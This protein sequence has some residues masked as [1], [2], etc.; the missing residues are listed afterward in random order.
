MKI[1]S[2]LALSLVLAFSTPAPEVA[3]PWASP[4]SVSA[5]A[6]QRTA[7]TV[8][9]DKGSGSGVVVRGSTGDVFCWTANHVIDGATSIRLVKQLQ[10]PL[11]TVGFFSVE[12]DI[13]GF[14][15]EQDLAV[16]KPRHST[17]FT[18]GA[19]F[20][21]D[22][23]V[24]KLGEPVTHVGSFFG[25]VNAESVSVGIVS[26]VGRVLDDGLSYFQVSCTAVP[27]SS[28]GGVWSADQKLIGVV[29]SG[30]SETISFVVPIQRIRAWAIA[31]GHPEWLPN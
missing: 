24:P 7:V 26:Y 16:L 19:S 22:D 21:S 5:E 17:F 18:Y 10:A 1:L 2:V 12:A 15:R 27:G 29:V 13:V 6:L 28:G 9:T 25:A 14:S 8:V 11:R 23:Y 20:A 4:V 3:P 30:Y 31:E